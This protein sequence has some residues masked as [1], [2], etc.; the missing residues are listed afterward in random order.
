MSFSQQIKMFGDRSAKAVQQTRTAVTIKLFSA[1]IRDTPVDTGLARANWQLTEGQKATG[2]VTNVAPNKAGLT[3]SEAGQI[4]K[5]NGDESL[6][7]TN[8]LPYIVK[9]EEGFSKKAPE[10]MVRRNIL[11]FAR[12]ITVEVQKQK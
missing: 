1:V 12:L 4:Q 11:R 6:Y 7:L 5:T 2:T 9:L 3:V 10:G 8:N